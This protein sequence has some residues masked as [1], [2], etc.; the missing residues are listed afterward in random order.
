MNESQIG[1]KQLSRQN[2]SNFSLIPL[3]YA[4]GSQPTI[5][6]IRAAPGK[7]PPYGGLHLAR[8]DSPQEFESAKFQV[9]DL[10]DSYA[11]R[12]PQP[13]LVS[14]MPLELQMAEGRFGR[15]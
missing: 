6:S 4:P 8:A 2:T 13:N 15:F 14:F 12:K 11:T 3:H 5:E 1:D 9:M 10:L 7:L